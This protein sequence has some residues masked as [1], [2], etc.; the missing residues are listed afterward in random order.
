MDWL[1]ERVRRSSYTGENRCWPCTILNSVLLTL[2]VG[3]LLY[4]GRKRTAVAV[5][6]AGIAGISL[7]GYLFPYTP[8]IAPKLAASLPVDVFDHDENP[9]PSGSL[10]ETTDSTTESPA[11]NAETAA[12]GVDGEP[13]E[14]PTEEPS[15]LN[16]VTQPNTPES[17]E[18][19]LETLLEAGVISF[20]GEDPD[21][22][23]ELDTEFRE[24]W[25]QEMA[26][27]RT[28]DLESLA[29]VA[30][31][32]TPSAVETRVHRTWGRPVI[33]LQSPDS[34]PVTLHEGVAIAEMAAARTLEGRVDDQTAR[35]AGRPLRSL[36]ESCPLCGDEVTISQSTC[37]D[38]VTRLGKEPAEKLICPSCNV[39]FFTF[40]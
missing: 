16:S 8:Q 21:G 6:T 20:N 18:A 32:L 14:E 13:T 23:V 28:H 38:E 11:P 2:L 29:E 15:S 22:A 27:L 39:R 1:F 7:R 30:A 26:A 5:G 34:R 31:S 9:V 12:T 24:A 37:C 3:T 33:V 4:R 19:I 17:G 10:A 25:H 36:L 40:E 35:A